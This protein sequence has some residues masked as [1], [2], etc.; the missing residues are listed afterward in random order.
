MKDE[1]TQ[2]EGF[3]IHEVQKSQILGFSPFEDQ[4]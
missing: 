3:L 2:F 4:I 1:I